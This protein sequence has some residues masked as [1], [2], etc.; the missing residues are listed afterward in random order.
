MSDDIRS[1][2][3]P[4]PFSP[5]KRSTRSGDHKDSSEGHHG[6]W[7]DAED[8]EPQQDKPEGLPL[9]SFA[10]EVDEGNERLRAAGKSVRLR[11]AGGP[12]E[13]FVEIV[14]PGETG[15]EVVARRIAPGEI[16]EWV[17]RLETTEGLMIDEKM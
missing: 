16:R 11:L 17:P 10:R 14:L 6:G 12:D 7:S 3:P 5:L 15:G 8:E 13:P 4:T 1:V 2:L 9:E